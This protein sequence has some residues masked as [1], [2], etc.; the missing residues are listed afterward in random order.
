MRATVFSEII[1]PSRARTYT[2]LC[3]HESAGLL[4]HARTYTHTRIH[5]T[6]VL[7]AAE[8]YA[9]S[10]AHTHTHIHTYTHTLIRVVL[11]VRRRRHQSSNA[12]ASAD[13][14]RRKHTHVRSHT[15]TSFIRY[16]ATPKRPRCA[17]YRALPA[18]IRPLRL[19]RTPRRGLSSRLSAHGRRPPL[20]THLARGF[21]G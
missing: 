8:K 9:H 10:F 1:V 15:R 16:R 18:V 5:I 12:T 2:P 13:I 20:A 4:V 21:R 17:L 11:V 7:R 14:F 3:A 19:M 6:C